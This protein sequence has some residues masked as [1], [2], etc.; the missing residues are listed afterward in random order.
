MNI[1]IL[2]LSLGGPKT[3]LDED[4]KTIA[5][6]D[7]TGDADPFVGVWSVRREIASKV[8]SRTPR[9]SSREKS[10]ASV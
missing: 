7:L 10:V 5:K 6:I 1:F 8:T 4:E 9:L 2:N 3:T